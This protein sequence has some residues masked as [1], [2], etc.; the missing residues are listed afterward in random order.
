MEKME[1]RKEGE[2][3]GSHSTFAFVQNP[4]PFKR[5]RLPCRKQTLL[6][7]REVQAVDM[8]VW[9]TALFSLVFAC[10]FFDIRLHSRSASILVYIFTSV[11]GVEIVG[12]GELGPKRVQAEIGHFQ[13]EPAV[14][15]AV[16]TLQVAMTTNVGAVYVTHCLRRSSS[17]SSSSSSLSRAVE[18][19]FKTRRLRFV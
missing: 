4:Q 5:H 1:G 3:D 14:D 7:G 17:S 12:L 13:Y 6:L 8:E 18:D 11:E 19:E 9:E 15:D 10:L 16:W 2:R